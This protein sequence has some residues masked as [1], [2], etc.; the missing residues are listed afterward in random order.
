MREVELMSALLSVEFDT[1]HQG[2]CCCGPLNLEQHCC[3]SITLASSHAA[4]NIIIV[5]QYT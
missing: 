5:A 3:A 2:Y 4:L 1:T